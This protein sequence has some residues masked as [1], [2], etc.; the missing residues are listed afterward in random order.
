MINE[1]KYTYKALLPDYFKNLKSQ[2][3][4]GRKKINQ[5]VFFLKSY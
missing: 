1:K 4:I 5:Y 2:G 3:E